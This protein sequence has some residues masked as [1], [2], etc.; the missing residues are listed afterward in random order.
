MKDKRGF[1]LAVGTIVIIVLSILLLVALLVIWNKQTGIFS[2]FLENIMGKS[3]V[4][5]IV[6]ACNT[7]VAKQS[8]YEYCCV[9]RE[10]KLDKLENSELELTCEQLSEE[11]FGKRVEKL[12]CEDVC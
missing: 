10:I 8:V 11:D 1:E 9:S 4:D 2:D 5:S 7:F 12:N 6:A 3:N